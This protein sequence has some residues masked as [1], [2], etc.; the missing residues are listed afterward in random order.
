[1]DAP[2]VKRVR[3]DPSPVVFTYVKPIPS[4]EEHRLEQEELW[5][6]FLKSLQIGP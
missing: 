3:F 5:E 2:T 4:K 6:R 1:M